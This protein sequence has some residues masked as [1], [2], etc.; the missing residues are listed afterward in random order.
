[1]NA[2]IAV[3]VAAVVGAGILLLVA[4]WPRAPQ[5]APDDAE[6]TGPSDRAIDGRLARLDRWS[7]IDRIR[8]LLP[9]EKRRQ[10]DELI[11]DLL[12]AKEPEPDKT[13]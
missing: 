10:F 6:Q 4:L 13:D 5:P 12:D 11:P 7:A 1:M 3:L 2:S 9:P 8:R